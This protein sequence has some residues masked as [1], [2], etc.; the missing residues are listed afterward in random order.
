MDRSVVVVS[1]LPRSG[2]SM[3]M[4]MLQAGGIPPLTDGARQA[5]EDNPRGYLEYEKAIRLKKDGSW[6]PEARGRAVKVVA[7]LLAWLPRLEG[8]EYIV[9]FMERDPE[10][11][12]KS[13]RVM[14]ARKGR[15][16][17]AITD[18]RLREIFSRQ[19]KQA[20]LVLA[21]RK[22]PTLS[23]SYDD[24]VREPASTVSR[25]KD[26][27]GDFLDAGKMMEVVDPALRRQKK[28]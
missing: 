16:G 22:I 17:A 23:I 27:F 10:E 4:Q 26:V 7:Q 13:Q 11:V 19:A 15:K 9:I 25:L 3:M 5:D 21:M 20:K 6:L 18:E 1:G 28:M 2:T 8:L 14:L 12:I 24:T